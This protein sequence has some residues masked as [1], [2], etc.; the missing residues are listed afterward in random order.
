MPNKITHLLYG[1][2]EAGVRAADRDG[3]RIVPTCIWWTIWKERSSRCSESKNCDLQM[4]KLNCL[5]FLFLVQTNI[6][7]DTDSIIDGSCQ[8][9]E[10]V[11]LSIDIYAHMVSVQPMY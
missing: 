8:D 10:L 1:W 9:F 3:W 2:E 4:I 6:L 7:E 5:T 11:F